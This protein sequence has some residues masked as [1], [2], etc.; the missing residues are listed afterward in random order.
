MDEDQ[1]QAGTELAHED[2]R[3][4]ERVQREIEHTRAE[5]GDTAAALAEKADVKG[6]AKRAAGEAMQ[7]VA[8]KASPVALV[9]LGAFA[10]G[11]LTG[12]WSV[13]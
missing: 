13:R 12:R 3:T 2:D 7:T 4:P 11:L 10:L 1:S 6:Q 9:A 8:G 5:L